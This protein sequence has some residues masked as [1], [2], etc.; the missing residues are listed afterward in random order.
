MTHHNLPGVLAGLAPI[1]DRYGYLAVGGFITL[2]DFGIP[3]PGET[4]L[5]AASVYAGAGELN[6]VLVIVIGIIAAILGDNIGF[7][8]GTFGGRRLVERYGRYVFISP[9]RLDKAERFFDRYGG[10][11]VVVARFI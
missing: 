11:V 6:I 1:L 4:I 10:W 3:V 9:E 7:A 2:E 5:I 8:I